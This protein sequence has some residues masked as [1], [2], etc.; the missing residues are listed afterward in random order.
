MIYI[1]KNRQ[2]GGEEERWRETKRN[3]ERYRESEIRKEINR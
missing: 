2:V 3:G 1:S